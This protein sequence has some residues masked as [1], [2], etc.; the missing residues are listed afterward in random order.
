MPR[1]TL[2][3]LAVVTAAVTAHAGAARAGGKVKADFLCG[4]YVDGDITAVVPG[5]KP[6]RIDQPVACVLHLSKPSRARYEGNIATV[7]HLRA[8]SGDATDS[9]TDGKVATVTHPPDDDATDV[10]LIMAPGQPGDDGEVM[11]DTCEDFAI[12][13]RLTDAS[14]ATVFEKTVEVKQGC[15]LRLPPPDP[16]PPGTFLGTGTGNTAVDWTLSGD[17][18][19]P[20][21][22]WGVQIGDARYYLLGG[23][24]GVDLETDCQATVYDGRGKQRA[25]VSATVI[26][27]MDEGATP[28][29][30]DLDAARQQLDEVL[31]HESG[32]ELGAH[33]LGAQPVTWEP[34]GFAWS[35]ARGSLTITTGGRTWK[36][37]KAPK[38]PRGM[39][40]TDAV[41][42]YL[43]GGDPEVGILKVHRQDVEGSMADDAMVA[44]PLPS[45][46]PE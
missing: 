4:V 35:A 19:Q 13:G 22:A 36:K 23:C 28:D 16:L 44:A 26:P 6:A 18:S 10:E 3:A 17:G 43:D 45:V 12:V 32:Y 27:P 31:Q 29:L 42:Y 11:F 8:P 30:T 38:T 39:V 20:W 37:V 7:R 21:R 24:R 34:L 5:K 41:I 46:S 33:P 2:A 1:L 40:I 25:H 15:P 9:F 14:G